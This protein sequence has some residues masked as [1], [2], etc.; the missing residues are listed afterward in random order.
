MIRMPFWPAKIVS[1]CAG[2]AEMA[3]GAT[4]GAKGAKA[5]PFKEEVNVWSQM[6]RHRLCA[7]CTALVDQQRR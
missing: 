7:C 1:A 4:G 3:L 6:L 5:T 2:R